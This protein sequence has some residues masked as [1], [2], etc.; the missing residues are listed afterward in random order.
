MY[1][2]KYMQLKD[3]VKHQN[4]Q[5]KQK[6]TW[7]QLIPGKY[8]LS[9]TFNSVRTLGHKV[10]SLMAVQV[11]QSLEQFYSIEYDYELKRTKRNKTCNRRKTPFERLRVLNS[12]KLD[13]NGHVRTSSHVWT[14]PD[15][16]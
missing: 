2:V 4:K 10:C 11:K 6:H 15:L 16:P 9:E 14:L 5:F 1:I 8:G 3:N 7:S 13:I 12:S